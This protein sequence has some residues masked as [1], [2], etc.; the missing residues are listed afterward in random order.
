VSFDGTSLWF[1]VD[2]PAMRERPAVVPL[3]GGPGSFDHTYF[4][5]EFARLTE[6]TQVVYLDLC[7]HRRSNWGKP[8][9]RSFEAAG[10]GPAGVSRASDRISHS[11]ANAQRTLRSL[12]GREATLGYGWSIKPARRRGIWITASEMKPDNR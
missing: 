3:L 12:S 6:V 1:D 4:K 11:S 10:V 5:P 2:G 9:A 8:S 7:E